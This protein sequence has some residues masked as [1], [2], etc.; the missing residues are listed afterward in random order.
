MCPFTLTPVSTLML[1]H[2]HWSERESVR[3]R[4]RLMVK[5]VLSN[6]KY[7]P[8]LQDAAAVCVLQA[9][10]FW[11]QSSSPSP[12]ILLTH[13]RKRCQF[14]QLLS[15]IEHQRGQVLLAGG[16]DVAAVLEL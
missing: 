5:G 4:L 1:R 16:D 11:V 6:E 14:A 12:P 8:D 9:E 2:L 3:T 13:A 15:F 7:P 10:A